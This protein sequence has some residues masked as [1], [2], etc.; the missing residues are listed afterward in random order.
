MKK[1]L[2]K[3]NI[4]PI[5]YIVVFFSLICGLFREIIVFILTIVIHELG[6][7]FV[8][9][10]FGW[11]IKKISFNVYG[12]FISYDE[13]IDKSFIEE[14]LIAL[15]GFLFQTIFFILSILLYKFNII[16]DNI[17]FLVKKYFLSLFLFN[18]IPIIPLDGSKILSVLLNLFF[19]YKKSLKILNYISLVSLI[20][21][22]ILIIYYHFTIE[23]SYII[24]FSF[25]VKNIVE[26]FYEEKYLFTKFLFQRYSLPSNYSKK[27]YINNYDLGKIKRQKNTYFLIN[28][29]YF[30]EE[31]ILKKLFD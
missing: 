11:N 24:I 17:L 21:I 16:D 28:G 1:C 14:L 12:G 8:S 27:I 9:Y 4:S 25:L 13:V 31:N 30:K 2:S 5:L 3:I 22:S 10:L 19:S 23:I 26:G 29:R 20:I 15:A 6:H 18:L 7:V